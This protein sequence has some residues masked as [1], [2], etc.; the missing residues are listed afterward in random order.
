M[1]LNSQFVFA[2]HKYL[3]NYQIQR[4]NIILDFMYVYHV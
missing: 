4:A 1:P 3:Q 2:Q